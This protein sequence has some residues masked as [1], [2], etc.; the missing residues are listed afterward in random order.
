MVRN[1]GGV[2]LDGHFLDL[3]LTTLDIV[4]MYVSVLINI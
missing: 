2:P 4:G 3:L 1:G